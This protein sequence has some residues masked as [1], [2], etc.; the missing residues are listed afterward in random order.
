M[1]PEGRGGGGGGKGG[2][3][4]LGFP[5]EPS[6]LDFGNVPQG[7]TMGRTL[8]LRNTG[9]APLSFTSA[10]RGDE[11][12]VDN[13]RL[14]GSSWRSFATSLNAQS[15]QSVEAALSVPSGSET[16]VAQ[17]TLIFWGQAQ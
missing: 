10:V 1:V 11:L 14:S 2:G 16:G 12:F 17:G 15:T 6:L 7:T 4:T 3:A 13:L 8:L 9:D 5:V